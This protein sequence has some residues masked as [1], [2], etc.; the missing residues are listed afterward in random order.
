[1]DN[2]EIE[3]GEKKGGKKGRERGGREHTTEITTGGEKE[4][5]FNRQ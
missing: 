1:M 2:R 3:G 5:K 4:G